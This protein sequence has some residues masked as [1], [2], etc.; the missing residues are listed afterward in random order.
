[1]YSIAHSDLAAMDLSDLL[2]IVAR[3]T[4]VF[5]CVGFYNELR[6]ALKHIRIMEWKHVNSATFETFY[7]QQL[8]LIQAFKTILSIMLDSDNKKWCPRVD[9]KEFGLIRLFKNLNDGSYVK[10]VLGCMS[11]NR[12]DSM[13]EFFE[14]YS[15]ILLDHYQVT[16]A[17]KQIPFESNMQFQQKHDDYIKRKRELFS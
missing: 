8:K 10:F 15:A 17:Y 9:D 4:R 11:S 2:R 12:F 3:E 7:N 1:M 16:I 14:E 13:N 6:D 5:N